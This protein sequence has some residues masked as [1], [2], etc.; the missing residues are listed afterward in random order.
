[1]ARG[2]ARK[3]AGRKA[4]KT[5]R[6]AVLARLAPEIRQQLERDAKRNRRSLSHEIEVRLDASIKTPP[7][8]GDRQIRALCHLITEIAKQLRHSA[9]AR[10]YGADHND[11][12]TNGFAFEAFRS[13]LVQLLDRLAPSSDIEDRRGT[14]PEREAQIAVEVLIALAERDEAEAYTVANQ[15]GS[16]SRDPVYTLP[17]A[18]RDLKLIPKK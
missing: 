6:V 2:G 1:M 7:K 11:W 5:R 16:R 18:A 8:A 13:A 15:I 3:G 4:G 17:R 14:T 9:A 12:R 10:G